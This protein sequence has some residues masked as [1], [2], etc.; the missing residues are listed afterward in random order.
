MNDKFLETL[1]KLMPHSIREYSFNLEQNDIKCQWTHTHTHDVQFYRRF[2]ELF[3]GL[4]LLSN[5]N[6]FISFKVNNKKDE[7]EIKMA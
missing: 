7:S 1:E 2:D 6:I 3:N 5:K 4:N